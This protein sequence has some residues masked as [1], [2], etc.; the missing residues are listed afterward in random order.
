MRAFVEQ[1]DELTGVCRPTGRT[2]YAEVELE[3]SD[4]LQ[5]G[6][7]LL[8]PVNPAHYGGRRR[9]GF[10]C[11]RVSGYGAAASMT[12]RCLERL[13]E[14]S[15]TGRVASCGC[16]LRRVTCRLRARSGASGEERLG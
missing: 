11:A 12:R 6:A 2:F 3:S 1:W 7:L 5:R 16:C 4:Y 13:D 15:I 8:A 10:A 9:C 14:E